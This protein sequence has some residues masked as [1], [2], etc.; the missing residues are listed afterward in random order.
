MG[1]GVCLYVSFV[2]NN[3]GMSVSFHWNS[4]YLVQQTARANFYFS[5]QKS[6]T[7]PLLPGYMRVLCPP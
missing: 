3:V 7:L 4:T 5:Y 6:P 2:V 1:A